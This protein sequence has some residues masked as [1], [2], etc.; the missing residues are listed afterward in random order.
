MDVNRIVVKRLSDE[1][2]RL[3][4]RVA[5]IDQAM[6]VLGHPPTMTLSKGG[7]AGL[8]PAQKAAKSAKLRAAWKL[9]KAKAA[10]QKAPKAKVAPKAKAKAKARK[11]AAAPAGAL[12]AAVA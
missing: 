2:I 4:T 9:R 3:L 11:P 1:K 6:T 5:A 7:S 8:T 12:A 10:A